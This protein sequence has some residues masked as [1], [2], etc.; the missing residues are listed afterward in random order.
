MAK[1]DLCGND[2]DKSFEVRMHH[3]QR[4]LSDKEAQLVGAQ[5]SLNEVK[6]ELA[7][8]KRL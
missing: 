7:R 4:L 6:M 8:L 1:C 3:L 5:A 2:Y